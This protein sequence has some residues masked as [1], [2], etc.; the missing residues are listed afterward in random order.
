MR[1]D[2]YITFQIFEQFEELICA[3]STRHG[4]HSKGQF[5]S[6]NMG[7]IKNDDNV[8]VM[9]NRRLFFKK[10]GIAENTVVLPDQIHSTN[11]KIVSSAGIVPKTDALITSNKDL[12]LGV[13][14]ADCFPVFLYVPEKKIIGIVHAGWKGA[15]QNIL[16]KTIDSLT[17]IHGVS[18]SDLYVAIGPG[19]QKEC[20]EVR[21]DVFKQFPETFLG[22]HQDTTKRFLNLSGYLNQ[23]LIS[24]NIP[25][26]QIY[27]TD[28]C[29]KCNYKRY[30]SY[31]RD[32]AKSGR[33]LG[34][35]GVR[36]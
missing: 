6:L 27:Q 26:E 24:K 28:D 10:L 12:F 15:V 32:G 19:L 23:Q 17:K 8:S 14:T 16:T 21:S 5:T 2:S 20:F 29:T 9:K 25:S 13:Q 31:R 33:M 4:G 34:I 36:I 35:I 7:N 1:D 22:T 18:S 11:L 3:F 30:Y